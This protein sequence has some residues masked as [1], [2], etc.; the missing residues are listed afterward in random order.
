MPACADVVDL[1]TYPIHELE[2]AHGQ[3]LVQACRP[4][5]ARTGACNLAGFS[6]PAIVAAMAAL[7]EALRDKAWT[8]SQPHTVYFEPVD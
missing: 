5:L 4:E 3:A 7:A 1:H 6:T 2:S 8:S